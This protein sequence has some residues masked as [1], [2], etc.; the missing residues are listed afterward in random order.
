MDIHI[1]SFEIER[2]DISTR[3]PFKYGIATMTHL[4]HV[5]IRIEAS[6]D[7][8]TVKGISADHLPPKWFTKE[9]NKDPLDEIGDMLAVI[10][11][12]A[13]LSK[14]IRASSVFSFWHKLYQAQDAWAAENNIPP[15]LAH[16]GTS[17]IERSLIDAFT[18]FKDQSFKQLLQSNA[19]GIDW[20]PLRPELAGLTPK[21]LLEAQSL[22]SITIRHTVGLADY[23]FENDI[24][25]E[26]LLS[27]GLPQSLEAVIQFY[28]VTHF[29]IKINGETESDI[30]RLI[31]IAALFRSID[32]EDF[33]FTLDGN[34]QF[35]EVSS[36]RKF[37]DTLQNDE[38]MRAFFKRLIFVEQP[39]HRDIALTEPIG[40]DLRAWNDAPPIIIDESDGSLDSLP[41]AL[42]LGYR[43]T[44]HKNCKGVFKGIIN[45]ATIV[46]RNRH[47]G[48]EHY[49]MSGEDLANI[50]PIANH[51]D[52]VVQSALGIQ[53]VE[54][55]GHH[56][57]KGLSIF[58][59]SI[60]DNAAECFQKLYTKDKNGYVRLNIQ[61]GELEIEEL[62]NRHFGTDAINLNLL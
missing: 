55:N 27:D 10:N 49:L 22:S 61:K 45:R 31:S 1:S 56:Y 44:S 52:L 59:Q 34:E 7:G 60:Q 14:E 21:D 23:L 32:L 50:G 47:L 13:T 28:G 42:E 53:S 24:P 15:L 4:P 5:F 12:A 57:F 3:M 16:F 36:F 17:L 51:Q 2:H 30:Q 6:F 58:N 62:T 20:A 40:T 25:A 37:W 26:E 11:Q 8:E 39:F 29:K 38:E 35:H 48:R 9:P 33:A 18:R 19:F 46:S 54:R 43:G 41:K